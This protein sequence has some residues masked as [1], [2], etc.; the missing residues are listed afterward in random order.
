MS[1]WCDPRTWD[2][3]LQISHVQENVGTASNGPAAAPQSQPQPTGQPVAAP[4]ASASDRV[5]E[6]EPVA[7]TSE[8]ASIPEAAEEPEDTEDKGISQFLCTA[9]A[10]SIAS[11][12]A[13]STQLS[14]HNCQHPSLLLCRAKQGQWR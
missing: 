1:S 4:E 6:V 10:L 13:N 9:F 8:E 11:A 12:A 2:F 7:S 14:A 3:S 5:E